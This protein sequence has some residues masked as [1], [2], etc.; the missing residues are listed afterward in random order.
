MSGKSVQWERSY[1]VRTY[2]QTD[3]C[4][5]P[6]SRFSHLF[7]NIWS[8]FH[9]TAQKNCMTK[10]PWFTE[11]IITKILQ[12]IRRQI[13][14]NRAFSENGKFIPTRQAFYAYWH[15]A[16]HWPKSERK[17][18]HQQIFSVRQHFALC[19]NTKKNG[20]QQAPYAFKTDT[21][22]WHLL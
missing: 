14:E 21:S 16:K 17:I 9:F 1:S 6:E 8:A 7:Q 3:V 2:G 4:A 19:R 11:P 5:E 15:P 18:R 10:S 12:P 13:R 20:K 22:L